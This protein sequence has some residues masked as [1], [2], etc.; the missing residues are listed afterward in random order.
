MPLRQF[1]P[2]TRAAQWSDTLAWIDPATGQPNDLTGATL[3]MALYPNDRAA[4]SGW[5]RGGDYGWPLSSRG[6]VPILSAQTHADGSGPFYILPDNLHAQWT[7]PAGTLANAAP[8]EAMLIV[9][10]TV[11]GATDEVTRAVIPVLDG[12]RTLPVPQF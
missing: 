9:W 12:P 7:F 4:R 3:T 11:N 5:W 1:Q 2:I 6:D 10:A 8:R